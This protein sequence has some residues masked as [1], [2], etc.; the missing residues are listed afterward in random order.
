VQRVLEIPVPVAAI[1]EASTEF[2]DRYLCTNAL[3]ADP[4]S[5]W[6]T[7]SQKEGPPSGYR[8]AAQAECMLA[9]KRALPQ[10]AVQGR[11][12]LSVGTWGHIPAGCSYKSATDN[13]AYWNNHVVGKE[14]GEF[15]AVDVDL[16]LH[17]GVWI[18]L[19][20]E[21]GETLIDRMAYRQRRGTEKNKDVLLEFSD[22]SKQTVTLWNNDTTGIFLLTP[23][24]TSFVTI[25]IQS[26]YGQGNNGAKEIHFYKPGGAEFDIQGRT[27]LNSGSWSQLPKG[28]SF[29]SNGDLAAHFN[30]HRKYPLAVTEFASI[31][32]RT[33]RS[34]GW[35][36]GV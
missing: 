27:H 17:L 15:T 36:N 21:A 35:Q 2:D 4:N 34:S 29:Q 32:S 1:C 30:R 7:H 31:W 10:G 6:A 13:A 18:T 9:V 26:V 12:D 23:V 22:G 14:D 3:D 8:T 5:G 33:I 20:F 11:L 25:T 24:T 28:C 19:S 16:D